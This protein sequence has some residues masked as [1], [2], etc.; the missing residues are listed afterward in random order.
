M[1]RTDIKILTT[2][3]QDGRLSNQGLADQAMNDELVLSRIDIRNA[4]MMSLEMQ[5]V[6]R[7]AALQLMQGRT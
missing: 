5:A 6:R 7:D 4:G 1:D 2:L 3:Q